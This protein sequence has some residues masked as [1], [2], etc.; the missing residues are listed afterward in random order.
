MDRETGRV[1]ITISPCPR[2]A[3]G[4]K[5]RGL[6]RWPATVGRELGAVAA[7]QGIK[8]ER[9]VRATGGER[10]LAGAPVP[11]EL[12]GGCRAPGRVHGRASLGD[13]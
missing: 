12:A 11:M 5:L 8:G 3:W 2:R 9:G 10:V 4:G 7:P 13:T 6:G 1:G